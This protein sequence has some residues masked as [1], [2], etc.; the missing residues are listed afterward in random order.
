MVN[1]LIQFCTQNLDCSNSQSLS[2]SFDILKNLPCQQRYVKIQ[3]PF[4]DSARVLVLVC[5]GCHKKIPQSGWLKQQ[6]LFFLPHSCKVQ[7]SKIE[8]SGNTVSG[9]SYLP[10]FIDSCL[11]ALCWGQGECGWEEVLWF[12]L[13]RT[14]ILSDKSPSYDLI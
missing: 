13:K 6:T 8:V 14:L 11:L 3:L 10:D 2:G 9:E 7:K 1:F 4:Q 12:L 5:S